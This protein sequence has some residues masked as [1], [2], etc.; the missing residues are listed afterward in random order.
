MD[1]VLQIGTFLVALA[2]LIISGLNH[3]RANRWRESDEGKAL[4]RRIDTLEGAPDWNETE[5]GRA[6]VAR[7]TFAEQKL[8]AGEE[9]F[10][11]LATKAD[12]AKLEAEISG[13]ERT[14][15]AKIGGV[16][17]AVAAVGEGVRRIESYFLEKGV[18]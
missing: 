4:V 5:S 6:I 1:Q 7:M 18:G 9:R 12:L 3:L 10:K 16:T 15:D 13:L 14:V 11:G 17:N 2:A 8:A